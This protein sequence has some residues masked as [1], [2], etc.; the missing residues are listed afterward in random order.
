MDIT[1]SLGEMTYRN[2]ADICVTQFNVIEGMSR[3]NGLVK[4]TDYKHMRETFDYF[5]SVAKCMPNSNLSE[6]EEAKF[7][8]FWHTAMKYL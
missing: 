3:L 8:V 4:T 1:I 5:W 7:N 6:R 2:A